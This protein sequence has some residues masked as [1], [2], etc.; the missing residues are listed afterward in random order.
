MSKLNYLDLEDSSNVNKYF[1]PRKVLPIPPN[2]AATIGRY[3]P[4]EVGWI[5]SACAQ[6]IINTSTNN[7]DDDLG[8]Q[9]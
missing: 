2:L 9:W 6:E 4:S 3:K 1:K 7:S 5:F 8:I